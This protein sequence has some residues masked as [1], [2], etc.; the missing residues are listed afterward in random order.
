MTEKQEDIHQS[1]YFLPIYRAFPHLE[2]V[3]AQIMGNDVL[4]RRNKRY[5]RKDSYKLCLLSLSLILSLL[6]L[7]FKEGNGWLLAAE[8]E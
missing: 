3:N 7:S 5:T 2:G 8:K 4:S 6:A 1:V